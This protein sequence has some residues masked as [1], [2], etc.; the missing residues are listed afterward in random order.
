MQD[1]W[2]HYPPTVVK[3]ETPA[4][5]AGGEVS[6][7]SFY[8]EER[9]LWRIQ[10]CIRIPAPYRR[11]REEGS[12]EIAKVKRSRQGIMLGEELDHRMPPLHVYMQGSGV[13]WEGL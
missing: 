5:I 2:Y 6:A 12:S 3:L 10:S 4:D 11:N 13:D 9:N 8:G 1:Q 7:S